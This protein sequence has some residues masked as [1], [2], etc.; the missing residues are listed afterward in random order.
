MA[1]YRGW[2]RD[3]FKNNY[4]NEK[5]K[6]LFTVKS[7]K[8]SPIVKIRYSLSNSTVLLLLLLHFLL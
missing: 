4:M 3:N 2:I 8:I 1:Q 6:Y 7:K 5:I